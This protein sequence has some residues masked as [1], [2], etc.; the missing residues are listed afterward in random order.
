MPGQPSIFCLAEPAPEKLDFADYDTR[1]LE[2]FRA[3]KGS[4]AG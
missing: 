2:P 3:Y 4:R 1:I